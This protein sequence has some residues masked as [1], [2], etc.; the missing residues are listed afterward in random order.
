MKAEWGMDYDHVTDKCYERP[1]CP[2]C[3]APVIKFDDGKYRCVSCRN[4]IDVDDEQ[5]LKWLT[6][7]E[8]TKVEMKD[9]PKFESN[10][11]TYGCGGKN[12]VETHYIRNN[13]TLKWQVAWGECTQCHMRFMV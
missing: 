8:D 10:G 9:C 1:V 2:E 11:H 5:M 3:D 4:V 7:R 6:D 12:T 13:V